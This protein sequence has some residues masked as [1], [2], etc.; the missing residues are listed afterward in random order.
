MR[1]LGLKRP[2]SRHLPEDPVNSHKN[3]KLAFQGRVLLASRV[4]YHHWRV[5][6]AAK[7]SSIS[8]RSARKW[9]S[10]FRKEGV[11]GLVDRSSRPHHS[12]T[13]TSSE[14]ESVIRAKR[15]ERKTGPQISRELQIPL[16]TVGRVLRR[17][18]MGKLPPVFPRPPVIRYERELPGELLHV[19]SKRLGR[20]APGL[21][22]HRIT[23][24][25]TRTYRHTKRIHPGWECL[26]V[27]IDDA[28]RLAYANI[29]P[30][31]SAETAL[32][33]IAEAL[34]WFESLGVRVERVMTDNALCYTRSKYQVMLNG[35]GISHLRIKPY[36][37]RTNGKAERFIQTLLREWA[38]RT[39]YLTSAERTRALTPY[40]RFY[41]H[42]RPHTSLGRRSPWDRLQEAV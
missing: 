13:R 12:P 24:K 21:I 8:D 29:F 2:T 16:S 33:F 19:D 9:I 26:H 37:P 7:A 28:S 39:P 36:T 35:L 6:E 32:R 30:D 3:A 41:N 17:L 1:M 22:G 23:G 5:V 14:I 27:A 15:L 42:R 11:Q 18:E 10:R 38:Y 40:L 4:I 31:E 34:N 25:K 20:I